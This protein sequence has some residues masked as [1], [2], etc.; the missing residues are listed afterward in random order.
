VEAGVSRLDDADD[1]EAERM[2]RWGPCRFCGAARAV[3][4]LVRETVLSSELPDLILTE[5][6]C[7][8]C[9]RVG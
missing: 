1:D 4:V 6:Y 7:P 3:R 2:A 5:R 9:G 8:A